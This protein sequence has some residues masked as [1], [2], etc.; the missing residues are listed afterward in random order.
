[1]PGES[2]SAA[3]FST[4]RIAKKIVAVSKRVDSMKRCTLSRRFF[5]PLPLLI[6]LSS[7]LAATIIPLNSEIVLSLLIANN[8]PITICLLTAS[9]GNWLG[10]I[11][12]YGLGR[13]G[14]WYYLEKYFGI[15][16]SRILDI[17]KYTSKMKSLLA[18]FC[19]LP[20]IGDAIAVALGFFRVNFF[21]VA[22]W[23]FIGKIIRYAFWI[24]FTLWGLSFF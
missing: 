8:Y 1:M 21:K 13:L 20:V 17:K 9:I 18:F 10:G 4:E 22:L 5:P 14:K 19:W 7:F 2:I 6:F 15:K 23:M 24:Y 12:S 11:T 16:E 3:A